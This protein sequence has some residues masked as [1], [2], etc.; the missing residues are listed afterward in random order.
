MPLFKFAKK[1]FDKALH[2]KVLK[3]MSLHGTLG[4]LAMDREPAWRQKK[5]H[6]CMKWEQEDSPGTS[7]RT[8]L[9]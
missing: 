3:I 4:S 1:L 7:V 8:S 2:E 5:T 9:I 6:F